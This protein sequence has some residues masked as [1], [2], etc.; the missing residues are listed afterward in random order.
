MSEQL[1]KY[2]SS[3]FAHELLNCNPIRH[4][5]VSDNNGQN[6]NHANLL[7]KKLAWVLQLDFQLV[8]FSCYGRRAVISRVEMYEKYM[9]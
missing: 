5:A 7:F 9:R 4:P 8:F 1:E 6:N 2:I 3:C